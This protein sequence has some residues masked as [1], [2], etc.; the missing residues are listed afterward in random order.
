MA[1]IS[2]QQEIDKLR[3]ELAAQT[4]L[5][6]DLK[7]SLSRVFRVLSKWTPDV[8]EARRLCLDTSPVQKWS[9]DV[10]NYQ[11][12]GGSYLAGRQLFYTRA[13]AEDYAEANED[14][15]GHSRAVVH[16]AKLSDKA[17]A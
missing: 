15:E 17:F 16:N 10:T 5:I 3:K 11:D 4:Q 12:N 1:K 6:G 8:I 14:D 9:V 2:K 7:S 13:A